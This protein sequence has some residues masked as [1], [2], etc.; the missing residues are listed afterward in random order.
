MFTED[1]GLQF[2]IGI[3]SEDPFNYFKDVKG[4]E[5]EDYLDIKINT[6]K[7]D[8]NELAFDE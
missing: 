7:A 3:A 4:R 1:D 8:Y 2:A 5:I 6:I